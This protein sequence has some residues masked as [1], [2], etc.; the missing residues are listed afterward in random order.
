MLSS[1]TSIPTYIGSAVG[2]RLLSMA[3]KRNFQHIKT[4]TPTKLAFNTTSFKFQKTQS[5]SRL[6]IS[7]TQI[8]FKSINASTDGSEIPDD[9]KNLTIEK[10]HEVADDTFETILED[11]DSFFE[12]NKI[13][14][15]DVDEEAGVMQINCSEGS[16]VINKQP[17]TK[18]IWLASPISG[19]KRF[20]YH[21]DEWISLRDNIKLADLLKNE[22]EL[23]YTDFNWSKPF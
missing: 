15:A 23:M 5:Q 9:V 17:P 20:D 13:M 1:A 18:Q 4:C 16:Y 19:P 7:H 2:R 3:T 22:M 8:R 6:A 12:K 11:L 10:Y 14:E 21:N